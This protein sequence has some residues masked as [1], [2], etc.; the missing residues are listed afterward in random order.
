MTNRLS[1]EQHNQEIGNLG[2]QRKSNEIQY[3]EAR[4]LALDNS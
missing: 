4:S 2:K 3:K 1:R